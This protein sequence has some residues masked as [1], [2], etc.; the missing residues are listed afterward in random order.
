MNINLSKP[1]PY[2]QLN[3]F[4]QYFNLKLKIHFI[5]KFKK[6]HMLHE[7]SRSCCFFLRQ[8]VNFL[9]DNRNLN[10]TNRLRYNAE[11]MFYYYKWLRPKSKSFHQP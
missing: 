1:N 6:Q 8:E 10:R 7:K 4:Q 9:I 3:K 5:V 11:H 2:N